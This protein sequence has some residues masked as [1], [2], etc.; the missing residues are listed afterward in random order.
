MKARHVGL[1]GAMVVAILLATTARSRATATLYTDREAF[2]AA[3]TGQS[4]GRVPDTEG[5]EEI[6]VDG[7]HL[8]CVSQRQ[9]RRSDAHVVITCYDIEVGENIWQHKGPGHYTPQLPCIGGDTDL[10]TNTGPEELRQHGAP[11]TCIQPPASTLR[12][13]RI[14]SF[15]GKASFE[16]LVRPFSACSTSDGR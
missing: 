16:T 11:R 2:L 10:R 6:L 7:N 5:S 12:A 14:R 15:S 4:L 1:A 3:A 13:S 9:A 8:I